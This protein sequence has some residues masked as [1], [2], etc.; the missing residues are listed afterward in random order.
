MSLERVD[1]KYQIEGMDCANCARTL[2]RSL[3]QLPGVEKV[4]INFTTT[5]LEASGVF[6]PQVLVGRV[7]ELGY[8]ASSEPRKVSSLPHAEGFMGFVRFLVAQRHTRMALFG[9]GLLIAATPLGWIEGIP[10]A[11][12]MLWILH[13]AAVIMAGGSIFRKGWVAL[14]K[15]RQVTIDLL[16]TIATL[17]A[18]IIGESGEAATVIV[19]FAAGE[20]LEGYTAERARR[21][22]HNLLA[23]RPERATVLRP[24][25]DCRE[26][27]GQDGYTGGPCPWCGVEEM[28]IPVEQVRLE[29]MVIVRPGERIPVDG[30]VIRGE[31]AVNQAPITGES[32]PVDKHPGMEV[33]AGTLNG[34]AVLEIQA[35]KPAS[36]ST[37]SRIVQLVE[38][39]QARRMPV[40]R[41]IDRFAAWYTP[42]VVIL[43]ALVAVVPPLL[44]QPFWDQADGTRGW[45]YRALGLLIVAC[46]CALVIST[47]VTVVSAL[48]GLARRGVL[49][50]GGAFLDRLADIHTFAFDKTGTL[51]Q[52]HPSVLQVRTLTCEKDGMRCTT[53]D[54]MIALAAAVESRSE[55]PLAQAILAEARQR[56][57][58][59]RYPAA[60]LVVAES[61]RGVSGR[62]NGRT[63]TVSSHNHEYNGIDEKAELHTLI[64]AAEA[65]GQTV[66][67]VRDEQEVFGF[68]GVADAVREESAQVLQ[69]LK[70]VIPELRT[71]MLTGDNPQAAEQIAAAAGG[72]DVVLAGLLPADKLAA[73]ER[74]Q[75]DEGGVVMIG[76]GIND[77]PALARADIGIAMGGAGSAQ[78]ME[79]ADIVLMQDHLEQL[80]DLASVSRKTRAIIWQNIIFSLGIKV[81]FMI[82]I[83]PGW[84]TLWAAVFA[85]MGASLIVTINGMRALQ[86]A[87]SLETEQ[88]AS[89]KELEK[90]YG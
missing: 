75:S 16:M 14:V 21:A 47:P 67:L 61:G 15:G 77:A 46:P 3:A 78:A 13:L 51:T 24:C 9:T 4:T 26:H 90:S 48:S 25:I 70:Q 39:A 31:S 40:E 87:I 71:A 7:Q 10:M 42:A 1:I 33:F 55:H 74:L 6:D 72:M 88:A 69:K 79:T 32:L 38:Q 22:L 58:A 83:L 66:I 59:N 43:A 57:L 28:Q 5:L 53:C 12:S 64:E 36:D 65:A 34:P 19:L 62:V 35:T 56:G 49:V 68:I 27:L 73:I 60:D 85:D 86:P 2:E 23:L 17:G 63:I 8:Q 84:A 52:G 76:D 44:G 45:L 20:A 37:I 11:Q 41:F 81:I 50:K 54:E 29:E 82:L 80:P 18:L 89:K 30:I